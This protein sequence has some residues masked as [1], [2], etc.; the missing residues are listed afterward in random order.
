LNTT[1]DHPG[2]SPAFP[3]LVVLLST[4]PTVNG[5]LLQGPST[6]L[7]G[8]FQIN[9]VALTNNGTKQLWSTWQIGAPTFG[10]NRQANLTVFVVNGTAPTSVTLPAQN[11][12]SNI[13]EVPFTIAG[14]QTAV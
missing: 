6:N 3:G 4:T 7:A 11:V 2:A 13:V 5:T 8:V 9:T 14:N 10:I 1:T 12:I